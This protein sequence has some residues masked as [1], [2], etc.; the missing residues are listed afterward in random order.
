[1]YG[2]LG[3][4]RGVCVGGGG[5][6]AG[7]QHRIVSRSTVPRWA[8]GNVDR[9]ADRSLRQL[10]RTGCSCRW[11]DCGL[12]QVRPLCGLSRR[13]RPTLIL[14]S[15]VAVCAGGHGRAWEVSAAKRTCSPSVLGQLRHSLATATSKGR[16]DGARSIYKYLVSIP[17]QQPRPSS[18][19]NGYYAASSA[20]AAVGCR[21]SRRVCTSACCTAPASRHR[22]AL[23]TAIDSTQLAAF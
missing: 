18:S 3:W 21:S 2:K 4:G 9:N 13:W 16:V 1:V 8:W 20:T 14:R 11:G 6:G 15:V 17:L 10:S 22:I 19:I 23:S 5:A 12:Q 7:L